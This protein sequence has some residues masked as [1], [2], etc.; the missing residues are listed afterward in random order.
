MNIFILDESPILAA[1]VQHDRHVVKMSLES[2]QMLS[3]ACKVDGFAR[4]A[5]AHSTMPDKDEILSFSLLGSLAPEIFTSAELMKPT[6]QNHPASVWVREHPANFI[7]LAIHLDA[8]MAEAHHRWPGKSRK[9]DALRFKFGALAASLSGLPHPTKPHRISC[10]FYTKDSSGNIVVN[11]KLVDYAMTHHTRFVYC[12]PESHRPDGHAWKYD[13]AGIIESYRA[14]YL[15]EK[16]PGNRWTRPDYMP[17][18][19]TG[20]ATIHR[21]VTQPSRQ[22]RQPRERKPFVIPPPHTQRPA[23]ANFLSRLANKT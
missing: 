14:Y 2:C 22:R 15:A 10:G 16:A 3:T 9:C 7:W 18:W 11:P 8:L 20:H 12:G 1:R 23:V 6:H 21:P 17:E 5:L 19:L 4:D 13:D